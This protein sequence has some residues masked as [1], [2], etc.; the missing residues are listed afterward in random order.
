MWSKIGFVFLFPAL[1]V[2]YLA[3]KF[4]AIYDLARG[5]LWW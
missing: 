1:V 5:K 4:K 3:A 2:L